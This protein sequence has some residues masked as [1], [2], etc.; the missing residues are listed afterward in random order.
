MSLHMA[1]TNRISKE[2][3]EQL[4]SNVSVYDNTR[5]VG[6][7]SIASFPNGTEI[8]IEENLDENGLLTVYKVKDSFTDREGKVHEYE[9]PGVLA[10]ENGKDVLV[11]TN[12]LLRFTFALNPDEIKNASPL[13]KNIMEAEDKRL[14]AILAN[15]A[16]KTIVFGKIKPML[17]EIVDYG[18]D[19]PT[20]KLFYPPALADE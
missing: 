6:Q 7:A 20:K 4:L 16:G 9:Y 1:N 3:R 10:I 13:C 17:L 19:K 18:K 14:G 2:S 11:N 5:G 8:F 15:F 12:R